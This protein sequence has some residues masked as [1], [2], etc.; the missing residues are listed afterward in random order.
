M[1]KYSKFQSYKTNKFRLKIKELSLHSSMIPYSKTHQITPHPKPL[2][3]HGQT[4]ANFS[5]SLEW[6]LR[7][8]KSS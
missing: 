1:T 8:I 5:A 2:Q 7:D 4:S 6:T 3:G